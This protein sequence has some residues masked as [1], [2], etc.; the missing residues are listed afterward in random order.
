MGFRGF[1][2]IAQ[3]DG[4]GDAT[5]IVKAGTIDTSGYQAIGAHAY[6]G[7]A[8]TLL[9][10][11]GKSTI[12]TTSGI[13]ANGILGTIA[14]VSNTKSL[15]LKNAG[16]LNTT[17]PDAYGIW[18]WHGGSGNILIENTGNI[19]AGGAGV[20]GIRAE[21]NTIATYDINVQS[22][23]ITSGSGTAAGIHVMGGSG[24]TVDIAAGASVDGSSSGV[25]IRDGDNNVDGVDEIGGNV[26][27]TTA[28]TVTGDAI[29]GLGDD[30]FNLTGGAYTGDI[31]G[32][33]IAASKNDGNDQFT[34]SGGT[35][36]GGFYG[37]NGSD[38]AIISGTAMFDGDEILDGGDD[39]GTGDGWNDTLTFAGASGIVN[40]K[41]IKNWEVVQ[42]AGP[43]TT[44][45]NDFVTPSVS[46][47]GGSVILGGASMANNVL[48]CVSDDTITITDNTVISNVI[49][50]AGGADTI[51][52][53]GNASVGAGVYG[54]NNGQD[55]SA[56][57]DTGDMIT[58]D[59]TGSVDLVHGGAGED[60]IF[61]KSGTVT[62]YIA[63]GDDNDYI[64]ASGGSAQIIVGNDGDDT[65]LV[66]G[67][68]KVISTKL[69]PDE[70]SIDGNAG[71]DIIQI[72]GN[73]IVSGDDGDDTLLLYG[74]TITTTFATGNG[75]SDGGAGEDL[76]ILDGTKVLG[77]I[78]GGLDN[79]TMLIKSGS[80]AIVAGLSHDDHIV[81]TGGEVDVLL[82]DVGGLFDDPNTGNDTIELLGGTIGTVMGDEGN[83]IIT[84]DGAI[85]SGT[86]AGDTIPSI[87]NPAPLPGSGDDQFIWTS[88]TMAAFD[89]GDGSDTADVSA[90][91]YDGSQIL[92]GGDDVS[93]AD[94]WIDTLNL[95][96]L[97]VNATG[98]NVIN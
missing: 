41:N 89:G 15:T 62:K 2:A 54:G 24:G 29:L 22:G 26:V 12:I 45:I 27:V 5:V 44:Q 65:I 77:A 23:T 60:R 6:V 82:G 11:V 87:Y 17:G 33:D 10:D 49:E 67:T 85:V 35:L 48:G 18:G 93:V 46:V 56:A 76:I 83:D 73:A 21:A 79:D 55:G 59:T 39:S 19:S 96:G 95:N 66:T 14:P 47:C 75:G 81:M 90:S 64:E 84:L 9:V 57:A 28:G 1:G 20:S 43:G 51:N 80:A 50:G 53:L 36:S 3:T 16:V 70:T 94:G 34:W 69:L 92:D 52:V 25:A 74:G 4:D 88:G 91:E 40:G 61:L 63:G 58:I 13:L 32:D 42:F 68:A 31:Y 38:N 72:D 86:I 30:T 37:Q 71:N 8:G 78:G 97:T 98:A 7:G